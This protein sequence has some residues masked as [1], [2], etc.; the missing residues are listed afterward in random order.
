MFLDA[1][2]KVL[3]NEHGVRHGGRSWQMK[4]IK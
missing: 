2:R 4:V 3:Y 1:P